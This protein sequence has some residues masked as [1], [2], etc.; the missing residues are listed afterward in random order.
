MK[1]KAVLNPLTFLVQNRQ[2]FT[3]ID[4]KS[5]EEEIILYTLVIELGRK[6][7][8]PVDLRSNLRFFRLEWSKCFDLFGHG[9]LVYKHTQNQFNES[10]LNINNSFFFKQNYNNF[11]CLM[12]LKYGKHQSNLSQDIERSLSF[13]TKLAQISNVW[14][15]VQGLFRFITARCKSQFRA[16]ENLHLIKRNIPTLKPLF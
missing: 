12:R 13:Q 4:R 11:N 3:G 10:S 1:E 14:R 7:Y 2:Q 6:A 16:L 8:L 5:L 15:N 9:L